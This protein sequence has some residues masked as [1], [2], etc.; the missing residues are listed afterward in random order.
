MEAEELNDEYSNDVGIEDPQ[1]RWRRISLSLNEIKDLVR[2]QGDNLN[3]K[4]LQNLDDRNASIMALEENKWK[5]RSR[6]M[7]KTWTS[8]R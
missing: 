4:W 3:S 6:T 2:E 7:P 8:N 5:K 1:G